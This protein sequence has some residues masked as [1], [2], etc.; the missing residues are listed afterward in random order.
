MKKIILTIFTVIILLPSQLFAFTSPQATISAGDIPNPNGYSTLYDCALDAQSNCTVFDIMPYL[1][2]A[3]DLHN[4]QNFN[5][6][7]IWAN[8]TP[9]K[10]FI[11]ANGYSIN[12][13]NHVWVSTD[14][15]FIPEV[16]PETGMSL[17]L[18]TA[19]ST[20]VGSFGFGFNDVV[21]YMKSLLLL[22]LG[23]GVGLL[24]TLLPYIIALV[25]LSVIV[26][27]VYVGFQYFRNK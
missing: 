23:S 26:K 17:L 24:Q 27:F 14:P 22:V 18:S 20:V 4:N 21:G 5:A 7:F 13:D 19:S 3:P 15:R 2:I 10:A 12:A 11:V 9:T 6:Y 25:I 16:I 8:S 1:P